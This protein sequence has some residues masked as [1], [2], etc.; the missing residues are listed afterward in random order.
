LALESALAVADELAVRADDADRLRVASVERARYHAEQARRRYL[1]VDPTN[2]LVADTLEADWNTALRELAEAT[3]AYEKAKTSAATLTEEQRRRITALAADFPTLWHNPATPARER[4]RMVRLLIED[5]T[6]GRDNTITVHIRLKG[7]Q[8]HSLAVKPPPTAGELRKTPPAVVTAIDTLLDEHTPAQIAEILNQRGLVT[9]MRQP[10]HRIIVWNI[11]R[12]YRLR[13]REQ[14]LRATGMLTLAEIAEHLDVHPLTV[15]RWRRAGIVTGQPYNDKENAFTQHPPARSTAPPSA[16]RP[17]RAWPDRN[18]HL[19]HDKGAQYGAT[20]LN[21]AS[22]GGANR[23]R[24]ANVPANAAAG[25]L[26]R[27]VPP[28]AD[29]RSHS[30]VRVTRPTPRMSAHMPDKMSPACRDGIIVAV[31]NRENANVITNTGNTRAC[32]TA[33]GMRGSGN[34]RSHWVSWPGS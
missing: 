21:S 17:S 7:G 19:K 3:D 28:I 27:P 16:A 18:D 23:K 30:S 2:R 10:F 8:T 6:I 20:S 24:V 33:T 11:I 9:G 1:A 29:S 13:D 25:T 15:K 31:M 22:R 4:K 26:T 14:R 5:V 32:P 34:H 12:D